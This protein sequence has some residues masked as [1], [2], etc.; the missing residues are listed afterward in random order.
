MKKKNNKSK[1]EVYWADLGKEKR[2]AG[3]ANLVCLLLKINV[4]IMNMS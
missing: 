3:S 4:K 2:K 1:E